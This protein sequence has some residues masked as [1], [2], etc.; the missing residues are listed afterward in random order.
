LFKIVFPLRNIHDI[1]GKKIYEQFL[2]IDI[3]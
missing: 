3:L 2:E 1:Y